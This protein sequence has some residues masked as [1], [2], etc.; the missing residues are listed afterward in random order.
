VVGFLLINLLVD[1]LYR[2]INPRLR[3]G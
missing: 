2:V 3:H 1:L